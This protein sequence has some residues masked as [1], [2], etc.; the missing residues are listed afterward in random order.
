MRIWVDGD[1]CPNTIK[2]I[3]YRAAER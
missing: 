2:E 1:A 3:L